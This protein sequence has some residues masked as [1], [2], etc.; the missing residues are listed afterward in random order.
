MAERLT[1]DV[2]VTCGDCGA[3][4]LI[5]QEYR[6]NYSP[7]KFCPQCGTPNLKLHKAPL[8]EMLRS[9]CFANIDH[10]LT[11]MLFSVWALDAVAIAKYPRFIDYLRYELE[12]GEA[13]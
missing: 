8:A 3:V 10:R 13:E 12:F 5:R 6:V 11:Q 4:T 7:V 2:Q 1:G 9:A